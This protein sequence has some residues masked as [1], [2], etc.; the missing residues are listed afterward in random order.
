[1]T[2]AM[3]GRAAH[4][5]SWPSNWRCSTRPFLGSNAPWSEA[6]FDATT[7]GLFHQRLSVRSIAGAIRAPCE[8]QLA[9]SLGLNFAA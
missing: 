9:Q 2:I 8:P 6:S 7:L 5:W 4:V 1:M 3:G